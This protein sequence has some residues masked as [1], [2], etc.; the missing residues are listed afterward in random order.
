[1][2]IAIVGAGAIGGYF[3]ANI[4]RAGLDVTLIDAW[5]EHVEHV[6]RHGLTV[7]GMSGNTSLN[8]KADI[9]HVGD[10]Q[11]LIRE[12][13][14]D[15]VFIAV[16]SYDTLWA[17]QLI[18]PYLAEDGV[19]ASLQNSLN[20]GEIASIAGSERTYGC[21]ITALACEL[22]EAGLVRRHSPTGS[23]SVGAIDS[24]NRANC[25]VIAG[26]LNHAESSVAID[27]LIGVKWSKLVI[28]AMRNGLSAMTGMTG[29]ERDTDPVTI[30]LGMRLGAQAVQVGRA[31]GYELV[32][33]GF[34]FDTLVATASGD[35][36]AIRIIR[37]RMAEIS[38]ARSSDQRPSMAQDI[39]KGRRTETDA[40]NGLVARLGR[41]VGV[42]AGAN[43]KV[44][45]TIQ[46][47]ERGE[48]QPSPALAAGIV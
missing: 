33:T 25:E 5:P 9:R 18:L 42:D 10:V 29:L 12:P 43:Q 38:G 4:I 39:R 1:M 26:I 41:E 13:A 2:R 20:E 17:T 40:I 35:C 47:I 45:E 28:N 11:G 8:V 22:R 23:V 30:E 37:S 32:D 15:V 44:H 34:S 31:L 48:L 46:R 21:A 19:V 16:K 24:K 7:E 27:N 14:F 36:D 3:G 6:R